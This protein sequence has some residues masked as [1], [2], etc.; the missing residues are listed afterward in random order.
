[1]GFGSLGL[2]SLGLGMIVKKMGM[3]NTSA[4]VKTAIVGHFLS[5]VAKKRYGRSFD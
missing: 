2:G 5:S 1:M 3:G 4:I